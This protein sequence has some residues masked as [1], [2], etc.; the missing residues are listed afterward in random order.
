MRNKTALVQ[1]SYKRDDSGLLGCDSS[2][3]GQKLLTFE[4]RTVVFIVKRPSSSTWQPFKTYGLT[5]H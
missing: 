1:H 2:L 5:V 3:L 4:R